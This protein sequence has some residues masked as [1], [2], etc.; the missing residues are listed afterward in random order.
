MSRLATAMNVLND[1]A[2]AAAFG[3]PAHRRGIAK[4]SEPADH[5]PYFS[6]TRNARIR[7]RRGIGDELAERR[8]FHIKI[9]LDFAMKFF[10]R[11]TLLLQPDLPFLQQNRVAPLSYCML[12]I[13]KRMVFDS[14]LQV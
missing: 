6:I 13:D 12:P 14:Q 3:R 1:R 9:S 7:W 8:F 2:N 4:K 5:T 10:S 11:L